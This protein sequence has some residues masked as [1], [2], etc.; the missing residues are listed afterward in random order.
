MSLGGPGRQT[1]EDVAYGA[2]G[3]LAVGGTETNVSVADPL[4]VTSGDGENWK[5]V[6]VTGDLARRADHPYLRT[7]AVTAGK[8]GYVVAGESKDQAGPGRRRPVVHAR[9][10]EVHP[11]GEA[12]AGR[13]R[14]SAST[15]SSP[16][17]TATWRWAARAARTRRPAWCGTRRTA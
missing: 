17:A 1:L 6:N 9:H 15:T 3:W 2:R 4:L 16:S 11:V 13:R 5:R 10:A 7:H 12:A 8:K 14:L